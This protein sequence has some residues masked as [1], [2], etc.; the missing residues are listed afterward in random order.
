MKTLIIYKSNYQ[1]NTEKIAK[2]MAKVM[3]A[4]LAKIEDVQPEDLEKYDLIGFGSGIY[5]SAL[6]KRLY[7]FAEEMPF[8]NKN[9]FIFCTSGS[10]RLD[11]RHPIREKF[12][13]KGCKVVG[14][15]SCFG[16]FKMLGF[17]LDKKG[18]PD[19]K[20]I[21]SARVFAK[22]LMNL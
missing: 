4:E 15:F 22:G 13:E 10:G 18:H 6:H 7:K 3:N 16:E 20:D 21:E 1:L 11:E 17:S 14:E 2:V 8:M 5:A 12:L 9:V 19:E